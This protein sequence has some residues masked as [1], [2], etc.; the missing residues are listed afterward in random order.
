VA[1][2]GLRILGGHARV[3]RPVRGPPPARA[4]CSD[5]GVRSRRS[6]S[7]V[8]AGAPRPSQCADRRRLRRRPR[9][10]A[11]TGWHRTADVHQ[12]L[13]RDGQ[14][15]LPS[16]AAGGMA[17]K[18]CQN[19]A[20]VVCSRD[21]SRVAP[22]LSSTHGWLCRSPRS[23]P[24]VSRG[25]RLPGW[26]AE[27]LS[28]SPHSSSSREHSSR[29]ASV[30]PIELV[31][32]GDRRVPRLKAGLLIPSIPS[33]WPVSANASAA[34][35]TSCA[36]SSGARPVRLRQRA[37]ARRLGPRGSWARLGRRRAEPRRPP[38][39]GDP[40]AISRSSR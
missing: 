17:A 31:V 22:S 24:T 35:S 5:A 9:G 2:Q 28:R 34:S 27:S 36:T 8:A 33:S 23:M 29:L 37:G 18:R 6:A 11:G 30:E 14:R 13:V 4:D 15:P 10:P 40:L 25:G 3:P 16:R 26:S 20:G 21:C 38:R 32:D 1:R 19:A 12:C 7:R 39:P